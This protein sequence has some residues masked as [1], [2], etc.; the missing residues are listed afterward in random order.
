VLFLFSC[1]TGSEQ[2]VEVQQLKLQ[3]IE[4]QKEIELR[5]SPK[6]GIWFTK[7][8]LYRSC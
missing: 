7:Y 4:K 6:I 5:K 2:Q 3:L 1:Q 8:K